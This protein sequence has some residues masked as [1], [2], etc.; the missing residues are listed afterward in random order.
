MVSV[1]WSTYHLPLL[2]LRPSA[3]P[4]APL[5]FAGAEKSKRPALQRLTLDEL[6]IVLEGR[7]SAWPNATV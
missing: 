2:L 7:H 6:M 3:E 1:G 5:F 4:S